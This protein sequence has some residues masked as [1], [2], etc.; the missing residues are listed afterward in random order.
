MQQALK[1]IPRGRLMIPELRKTGE[2]MLTTTEAAQYL[3]A[4]INT[5]RRWAD[6]GLLRAYRVGPRGDRRFLR[7]DIV[8]FLVEYYRPGNGKGE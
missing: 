2:G 3:Y 6:Q 7:D 5:V 1:E 4:H 8:R